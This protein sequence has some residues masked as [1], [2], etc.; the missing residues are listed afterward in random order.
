VALVAA[1]GLVVAARR[2]RRLA[3]WSAAAAA[4]LAAAVAMPSASAQ[5][6]LKVDVD[7]REMATRDMTD[8]GNTVSGFQQFILTGTVPATGNAPAVGTTV[9]RSLLGGYDVSVTP[10]NAAGTN[11]GNIDDRDRATPTGTPTFNQLYDDFMF[12]AAGVGVGGGIDL[13]ITGGALAPNQQYSFSLYSYDS[14]STGVT[15]TANWLDGNDGNAQLFVSSFAGATLPTS[16][17]Q[18]RYTALARTDATGKL[19][20]RGRN[21]LATTDPSVFI[22]GFEIAVPIELTLEVN[23]TTGVMTIKNQQAV[24][25]DLSYYEI[26][27]TAGSL[28]TTGWTSFDD[29]NFGGANTWIEAGGSSANILS[30]AS[31]T[32]MRSF[33]PGATAGLGAGFTSGGAQDVRFQYAA[34]GETSL[35]S[36]L[37]SYVTGGGVVGDFNG[38]GTVNGPDLTDWK[39]DFGVDGESDADADGDSD[40][41]DFLI[42]QRRLGATSGVAASAAVPEPSTA[43]LAA[44]VAAALAGW[45]RKRAG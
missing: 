33:A 43:A 41:N 4:L 34:P 29:A 25:F 9:T 2:R 26:R 19:F 37:V 31:L 8:V 17:N 22:N 39:G 28:S 10:V 1:A 15:R 32:S 21:A 27:S 38:D 42:W 5:T 7:D 12:T 6:L 16:D 18:Y 24:S 35:R 11:V 36:G 44:V 23:T 20:I 13:T 45:R 14:G 3:A 40:G 30:E